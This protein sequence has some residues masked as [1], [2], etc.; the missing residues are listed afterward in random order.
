[1]AELKTVFNRGFWEGGYYCGKKVGEWAGRSNSGAEQ[2][3]VQLGRVSN[4]FSKIGVMEFK[5][6]QPALRPGERLLVIGPTTG[7]VEFEIESLHVAG[8]PTEKA[9]MHDVVTVPAPVKVRRS[10]KVFRLEPR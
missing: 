1:M 7:A 5:L 9:G 10:D 2:V 8:K 4:W 3:R 6:C